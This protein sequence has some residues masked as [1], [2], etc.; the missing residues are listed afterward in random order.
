MSKVIKSK[1]TFL[2]NTTGGKHPR[3]LYKCEC[4]KIKEIIT[5]SVQKGLIVSCGCYRLSIVTKHGKKNDPLYKAWCRMISRTKAKSGRSLRDYSARGVKVCDE[6]RHDFMAFYNWSLNNG[7]QAGLQ[8]DKD[9]K[10]DGLLYSP[11]TCSWVT[12]KD[13]NNKK[14]NSRLVEY[15]GDIKSVTQWAERFNIT[16]DTLRRRLRANNWVMDASMQQPARF[17]SDIKAKN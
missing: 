1:L 9:I 11:N 8:L 4:G 12:C 10:G 16:V 6:W 13:N 14:R 5:H 15:N 17:K 2:Q 7:W 3:A